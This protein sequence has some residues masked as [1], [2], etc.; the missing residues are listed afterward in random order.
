[1]TSGELSRVMF[2][3]GEVVE[4]R[5]QKDGSYTVWYPEEGWLPTAPGQKHPF[6]KSYYAPVD[7]DDAKAWATE[8]AAGEREVKLIPYVDR[9][10]KKKSVT[11]RVIESERDEDFD[12]S[13][14]EQLVEEKKEAEDADAG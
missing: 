3:P 2:I 12:I 6:V 9:K 7:L 11:A 1:M 14:L 8:L 5:E 13:K 4:I 10:G